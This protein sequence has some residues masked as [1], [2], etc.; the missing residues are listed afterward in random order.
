MDRW[1]LA[2][3]FMRTLMIV[4]LA[5]GIEAGLLLCGVGRRRARGLRLQGAMHALMTAVLLR[6]GR[7][8]KV[9]S[10]PSLS[11]RADSGTS[12]GAA[13]TERRA[14]VAS[15]RKR[16][17]E[18]ANSAVKTGALPRSSPAR[19]CQQI[20][21]RL[22]VN[23]N[24]SIRVPSP[25]EPA[26]E[27]DRPFII[28][29]VHRCKRPLCSIARRR[30]L[31]RNRP[32]LLEQ[33]A[34]RRGRRPLWPDAGSSSARSLRGPIEEAARTPRWSDPRPIG[35]VRTLQWRMQRSANHFASPLSRRLRHS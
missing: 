28:G 12:P 3:G 15:D 25:H 33:I 14:I 26:L 11:H 19:A 35:P 34:Y 4:V 31:G 8:D 13:R 18:A 1:N 27:V 32:S 30:R 22:S 5:K 20:A 24:G 2:K 23:V 29:C 17:A 6:R 21:L 9:R 16:Q 10:M 7:A